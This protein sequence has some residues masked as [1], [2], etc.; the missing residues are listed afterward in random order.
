MGETNERS[1]SRAEEQLFQYGVQI[2]A[3]SGR[4]EEQ[5]EWM[6]RC[7]QLLG[8]VAGFAPDTPSSSAFRTFSHT[9]LKNTERLFMSLM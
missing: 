1:K 2:S 8:T 9:W 7:Q 4:G 5:P 3:C 6:Y